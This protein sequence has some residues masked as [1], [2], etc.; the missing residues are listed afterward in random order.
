LWLETIVAIRGASIVRRQLDSCG[1]CA[2]TASL[3]LRSKRGASGGSSPIDPPE[4]GSNVL[5]AP[6]ESG[7]LDQAQDRR[8]QAI[9]VSFCL[10]ASP[11]LDR[12]RGDVVQVRERTIRETEGRHH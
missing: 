1:N 9:H 7:D 8:L 2:V 4:P 3:R 11:R 6:T 5:A 10:L 12:V